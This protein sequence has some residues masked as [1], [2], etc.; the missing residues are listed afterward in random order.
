VFSQGG[1]S[2]GKRSGDLE[3]PAALGETFNRLDYCVASAYFKKNA[4]GMRELVECAFLFS[5]RGDKP[6]C[7]FLSLSNDY[8]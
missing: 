7:S 8:A 4:H 2:S 6:S 5:K 3:F 1:I